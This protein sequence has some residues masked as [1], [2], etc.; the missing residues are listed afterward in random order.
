MPITPLIPHIRAHFDSLADRLATFDRHE[1]QVEG[2]FKGELIHLLNRDSAMLGIA[3]V[4]REVKVNGGKVDVAAFLADGRTVW[5]E[6]KH[7]RIGLQR[8]TKW[9]FTGTVRDPSAFGLVKDV[10]KLASARCRGSGFALVLCTAN[11]GRE[12][13]NQGLIH[14]NAKLAPS[15][16]E[17]MSDPADYPASHFL[18]VLRVL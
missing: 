7:W 11:P 12:D 6:L 17:A 16:V 3:R 14:L 4:D 1:F 18:G 10:S 2:W 5:I 8:G 9:T 13:W 15:R